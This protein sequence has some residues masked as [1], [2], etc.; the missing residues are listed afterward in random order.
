MNSVTYINEFDAIEYF[1]QK[2]KFLK[3]QYRGTLLLLIVS[4]IA[5]YLLVDKFQRMRVDETMSQK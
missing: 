3:K 2:D 5:A 1:K 4:G